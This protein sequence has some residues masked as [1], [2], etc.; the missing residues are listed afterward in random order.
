ML[1]LLCYLRRP[2]KAPE[3]LFAYAPH[4]LKAL[5]LWSLGATLAEF[6]TPVQELK[7]EEQYDQGE[8]SVSSS[9]MPPWAMTLQAHLVCIHPVLSLWAASRQLTLDERLA[10]C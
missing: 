8:E 9:I 7:Q 4:A 3:L 2:Y 6:F 5:D 1:M 10:T